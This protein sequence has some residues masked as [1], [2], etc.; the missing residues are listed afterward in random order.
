MDL[1]SPVEMWYSAL[2]HWPSLAW[3][4]HAPGSPRTRH[5]GSPQLAVYIWMFPLSSEGLCLAFLFAL[6]RACPKFIYFCLKTGK[7]APATTRCPVLSSMFSAV[8]GSWT[9]S[10]FVFILRKLGIVADTMTVVTAH[11]GQCPQ[12]MFPLM[13][14][15]RQRTILFVLRSL[16][17]GCWAVVVLRVCCHSIREATPSSERCSW[18]L[19]S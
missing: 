19:S 8:P 14:T 15:S 12:G 1:K 3:L 10:C 6:E 2:K 18:V 7:K 16:G 4:C 9:E 17:L 13:S 11:S 5:P